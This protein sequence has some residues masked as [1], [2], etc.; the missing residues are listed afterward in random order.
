MPDGVPTVSQLTAELAA[1]DLGAEGALALAPQ[2]ATRPRPARRALGVLFW[3]SAAWLGL[4]VLL[5]VLAPVLPLKAPNFQDYSVVN[6]G[7]S[8]HHLLGTDDLGRDLV[9]RI[10]FGSRPSLII[11]F[12]SISIGLVVGGVMGLLAGFRGGVV[13]GAFNA[14]SFV[15]LA[16]PALLAI[17]VIEEFWGRSLLKLVI[18]F[19]FVATP[20]LFRVMRATTLSFANREFVVAARALGATT[21][22]I[23]L[24]ELLPNVIPAALSFALIGV[25]LAIVLEG[26]LAY[27]GLSIKLP[28]PSLGNIINEGVNNN[29]LS[30]NPYIALWPSVYIFL[31]LTTLNLMSDRLRSW[32]DV[33]EGRL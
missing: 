27:L 16:F 28:T 2:S 3:V 10:I 25:A 14:V 24:R 31:L 20:Q 4:M 12:A 23:L 17:I 26:S 15:I 6:R 33:R 18:L 29:N 30:T 13:D 9:S 19:A 5:A 7:P 11:G 32:F 21:R 1:A 8:I 22:R